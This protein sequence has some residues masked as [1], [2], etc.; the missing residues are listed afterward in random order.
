MDVGDFS[1]DDTFLLTDWMA[2]VPIEGMLRLLPNMNFT[3]LF[4]SFVQELQDVRIFLSD[5]G[6]LSDILTAILRLLLTF[7]RKSCTSS[8]PVRS[9][10]VVL[11]ADLTPGLQLFLNPTRLHQRVRLAQFPIRL[12]SHSQR[13]P[14]RHMRAE[15][16]RSSIRG[17][18][19]LQRQFLLLR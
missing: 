5:R 16:L 17:P 15:V 19:P 10:A 4:T 18:S 12:L 11:D 8:Q 9:H 1:E 6:H 14:R 13:R 7:L 2:H 3:D